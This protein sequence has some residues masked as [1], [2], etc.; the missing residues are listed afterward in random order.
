MKTLRNGVG[1]LSLIIDKEHN[2]FG[3]HLMNEHGAHG[4]SPAGGAETVTRLKRHHVVI[5]A[6][7]LE[8][9]ATIRQTVYG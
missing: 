5:P 6:V 4:S 3:D 1:I 2:Q 7:N 9:E 8:V